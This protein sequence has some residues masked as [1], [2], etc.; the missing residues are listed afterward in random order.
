LEKIKLY[1]QKMKKIEL[2]NE[3]WDSK[4]TFKLI[5][6]LTKLK[7][8]SPIVEGIITVNGEIVLNLADR[9]NLV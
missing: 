5:K 6:I 3:T 7:S 2:S 8:T 9:E 4:T 1:Q